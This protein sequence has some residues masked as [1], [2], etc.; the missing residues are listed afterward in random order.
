M[1]LWWNILAGSDIGLWW[2]LTTTK[3]KANS[4]IGY[5][6]SPLL[7]PVNTVKVSML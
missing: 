6:M 7:N 2:D 1:S 3:S 5:I 4:D